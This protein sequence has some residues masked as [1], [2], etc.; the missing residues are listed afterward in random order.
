MGSSQSSAQDSATL[1]VAED[2]MTSGKTGVH[3]CS[4][5]M[6][7]VKV[8]DFLAMEG[9][10]EPHQV[11]R[12]KGLLHEWQPSMFVIFASHQW[13]GN[14]SPDPSG[15]QMTVLR[16]ALQ[17]WIDGSM[18]VE[19][20]L[21]RT[22]GDQSGFTTSYER[23]ATAYLFL[24]WFAIPQLT[25]RADGVND[26]ATTSDTARAVQSIPAYVEACDMF[27]ALVPDLVHTDTGLQCN[28][29]TW[30]SRG[31]CRAE[32]WCRL[33]SNRED[34]RVVL[35]FS[36]R[37]ALFIM[38]LDWQRSLIADGLFTV[39]SD[40]TV[41][42]KL[43]ERALRSKIEHLDRW[44]PLTDY[45]FYLAQEPRLLNQQHGGFS[46]QGFLRHFSFP[47]LHDAVK[48]ESGMTGML[49]ALFAGD[50]DMLQSL[51]K[52]SA[53]VNARISGIGHLGYSDTLT[54]LMVAAFSSQEPKI[55]ST[56]IMSRADPDTVCVSEA[57][58]LVTAACLASQ[59]GHVQVLLEKK[60]DLV[61][62]P[63]LTG[64]CTV[65]SASTVKAFLEARCDPGTI[66]PNGYGPM[67]SLCFSGRGSPDAPAILQMLLSSRG[68]AN[69]RATP[70]G[71]LY[72]ECLRARVSA[73]LWGLEGC[74]VYQ[75]QMASLPGA[76]PLSIAAV[77]GDQ[78]LVKLLL[79][80]NAEPVANDRGDTPED[81]ARA[82]GHTDVLP[83]LSTFYV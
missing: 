11:L 43:G 1:E 80:H 8:S 67:Y 31:W 39:E 81:L 66:S 33:F 50:A 63:P 74:T 77:M 22:F 51:V 72:K 70:R 29:G 73:A 42:M 79:E 49:C 27:V 46:L 34:T 54:L 4:F 76:T 44:G 14:G 10:P 57:G 9:V 28:Y 36:G 52:H 41:V 83:L 25:E 19:V 16:R 40:R 59:P 62:S 65:S 7:V 35:I 24:D 15:Q 26:D 5:P 53:D 30:L 55:L 45:R 82:A 3:Q 17:S 23:V 13:L 18:T 21:M 64:A 2:G 61:T 75:R 48:H 20:D 68:D 60:A 6:Y 32:L 69:A 38:P 78:N 12:R 37:E 56:L 58:S 71:L 47:S